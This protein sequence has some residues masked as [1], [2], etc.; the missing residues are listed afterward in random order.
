MS[1]IALNEA[2]WQTWWDNQTTPAAVPTDE[3]ALAGRQLFANNCQ[4]CHVVND[5]GADEVLFYD[6]DHT[7]N[8]ALV[9]KAAPNLTHFASRSTFAG[10]IFGVYAGGPDGSTDANDDALDPDVYV[11]LSVLASDPTTP[12]DY[13]FN[14][15]ELK[16]WIA[17]A[18]SQKAMAP[19]PVEETGLGR[20]M[21]AFTFSDEELDQLVAYLATLD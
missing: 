18:P 20:G 21:P 13:R 12:E 10:G 1:A 5:D 17:N 8:I 11:D 16:R 4:R 15:A 19:D 9:S 2:D 3:E 14:A 6:V 7:T